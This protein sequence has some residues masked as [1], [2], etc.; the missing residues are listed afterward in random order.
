[1]GV[2]DVVVI[3]I[4]VAIVAAI[5]VKSTIFKGPKWERDMRKRGKEGGR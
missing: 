1:M 2:A 5:V 3:A 4:L